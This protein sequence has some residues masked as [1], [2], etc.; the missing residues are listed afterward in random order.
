[1][2]DRRDFQDMFFFR[3]MEMQTFALHHVQMRAPGNHNHVI[4]I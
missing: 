3:R 1:M 2:G 4:A